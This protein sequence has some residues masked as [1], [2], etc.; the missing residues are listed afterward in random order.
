MTLMGKNALIAISV[1]VLTACGESEPSSAAMPETTPA[2]TSSSVPLAQTAEANLDPLARGE[3][4]FKR[5]VACHTLDIDGKHKVGPNL[6]AVFGAK[7]GAKED[8][9]YSKAMVA[10]GIVW[11]DETMDAYLARPSK[12]IPGNRMSFVGLNKSEDRAAVIA[13]LKVKTAE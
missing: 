12:N 8:F 9:N 2:S 5:C 11:T 3:R 1:L 13:Y 10:S 6:H 7:A 4:L